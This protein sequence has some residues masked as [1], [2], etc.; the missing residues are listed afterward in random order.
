MALEAAPTRRWLG[1]V[2]PIRHLDPTLIFV[3]IGL[4][5]YGL[6]MVYSATHRA[7]ASFGDDPG[8][9]LKKQLAFM[10]LGLIVLVFSA[11]L[12]YRLVKV[13]SPFIFGICG[14]FLFL[15]LTP[16]GSETAG[17]QRWLTLFGFQFQPSE[18]TKLA[19]IAMLAAYLSE[20]RGPVRLEHV[21]RA[22]GLTLIPMLLV[23]IQPDIGTSMIFAVILVAMLIVSGARA[24]HIGILALAAL[25]ALFAAFR[26]GAV[27]E[28]Q[29][30]RLLGFFDPANDPLRAG[31]NRA[32]AEIA[33]GAGGLFG[34]GYG[35]GTQTNLD[36]VPEQ[37]TDFI[38]TVVGE[39]FGFVGAVLLLS[40]YGILLWRGFRVAMLSKDTFGS[41]L[42]LGI[43]GMLA[44][45]VFVNVGMTVG[46]MPIT[47][48]PLPF[49][50]Y[51]GTA[52][53]TN[54]LAVGL[55]LNVHMRR[56]K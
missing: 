32:Q 41:L 46:I 8:F 35:S 29:V 2:A 47:G 45:Q 24:K 21:W 50:S 15:V 26:L 56:F 22:T 30:D 53:L 48:I 33:I 52:L 51:G 19:L 31:Y 55:L 10:M 16:L 37:H 5:I 20:L 9:Y 17:A 27:Q 23:A 28:Y 18:I 25:I 43:V 6:L 54:F 42:A 7:L 11:V 38:F 44:F 34:T 12:D 1:E 13:Y 49:L 40:M 36:F 4:T 3:S 14:F 39:E